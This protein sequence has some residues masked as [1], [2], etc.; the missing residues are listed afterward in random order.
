MN[1]TTIRLVY[2]KEGVVSKERIRQGNS[3][4]YIVMWAG[5]IVKCGNEGMIVGDVDCDVGC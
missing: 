5:W 2:V 4:G 3:V 1:Y